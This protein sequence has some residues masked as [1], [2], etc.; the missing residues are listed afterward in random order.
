MFCDE[1]YMIGEV[2]C[3]GIA[4]FVKLRIRVLVKIKVLWYAIQLMF[5]MVNYGQLVCFGWELMWIDERN[6]WISSMLNG[7]NFGPLSPVGLN[8]YNVSY[9]ALI[10]M[11]IIGDE[12]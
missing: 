12:T 8:E 10:G 2:E 3:Y 6:W 7:Q 9:I 11:R 4:W 1:V 5:I